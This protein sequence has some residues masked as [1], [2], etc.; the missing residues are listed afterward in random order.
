MRL[1]DWMML[2]YILERH[3]IEG[4]PASQIPDELKSAFDQ[5]E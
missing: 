1:E 3:L 2:I 5:H 4:Q